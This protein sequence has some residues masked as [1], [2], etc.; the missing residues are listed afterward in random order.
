MNKSIAKILQYIILCFVLA[1]LLFLLMFYNGSHNTQKAIVIIASA[2]YVLWGYY[3]HTKERSAD[4]SV[5][6]EY[7]LYGVLGGS[8]ILSLLN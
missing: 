2:W 1:V 5:V 7:L 6:V 3:H 4:L 8:L